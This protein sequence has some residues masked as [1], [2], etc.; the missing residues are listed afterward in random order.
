[1]FGPRM[2]VKRTINVE[3]LKPTESSIDITSLI[4]NYD[5]LMDGV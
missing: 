2:N 5:K 1:M 3:E 4:E